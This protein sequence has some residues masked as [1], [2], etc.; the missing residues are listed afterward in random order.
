MTVTVSGTMTKPAF[1]GEVW[2]AYSGQWY[3]RIKSRNHKIVAA[4]EGYKSKSD[5]VNIVERMGFPIKETASK[6]SGK[7]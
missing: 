5:A 7:R 2:K 6:V 1:Y 4:S 3:F